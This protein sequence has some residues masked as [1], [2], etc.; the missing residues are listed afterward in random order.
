M[1]IWLKPDKMK[2]YG[3]MPSD[4]TAALAEQNI[5]AAPGSFGENSNMAYEYTMRYKGR[6][7]TP[8][9]YGNIIISSNTNGQTLHLRDVASIE[10]GSLMYSVS[11]KNNGQ[12]SSMGM[13]EQIA[14]SNATQ[15][16]NN[17]KAELKKQA[18]S[19]PSYLSP[20]HSWAEFR[21]PSIR[22]S[23]SRWPSVLSSLH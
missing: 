21:E 15:I 6:L 22:S 11:M 12:P 4:I 17:V 23:E 18:K 1:R 19:F 5:E 13:V 9:E 8:E 7:K 20:F 3:L 14:G 10:L 16:A 2:Q